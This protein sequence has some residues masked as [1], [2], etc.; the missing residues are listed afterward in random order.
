MIPK[1]LHAYSTQLNKAFTLLALLCI[2][3]IIPVV[4]TDLTVN[5]HNVKPGDYPIFTI[6]VTNTG[7]IALNPVSVVDTL[8]KGMS[9]V[10]DDYSP[11]GALQDDK[12]IWPN[13]GPLGIGESKPI[14]LTTNIA[15]DAS[16]RLTNDVSVTGT[17]VPDGYSVSDS[18]EEYVDIS[19]YEEEQAK[20]QNFQDMRVGDQ[21]SISTGEGRSVNTIKLISDQQ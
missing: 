17:P 8:P 12:V 13:I 18:D 10:S 16:G 7:E 19:V 1:D 21:I 20:E 2:T 11:K 3:I 6:N 4:S 9:Y 14:H 15:S 5:S